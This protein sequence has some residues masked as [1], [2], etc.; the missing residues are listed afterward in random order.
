MGNIAHI[1]Q[2][3]HDKSRNF[4]M[5]IQDFCKHF[6]DV[7]EARGISPYWQ[8]TSVTSS[9]AR[10]SFP[11]IC[12]SSPTQAVFVLSQSDRRWT[13]QSRYKNSIGLR[14]YRSRTVAPPR[15]AVGVKQNVSSPFK[16]L[17]LLGKRELS[18]AHSVVIEVA[19]MEPNT[20]YIAAIDSEYPGANLL[21]R[22]YTACPPRLR[23][24]TQPE[25]Q[26]LLQAQATAPIAADHDSFSS[27]GSH[28]DHLDN[29]AHGM[30]S[31]PHPQ[32]AYVYEDAHY[33]PDHYG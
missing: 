6:N 4:W 28:A 26:Y 10:P 12:V 25:T 24:L 1:L 21:L 31:P 23:E 20:L 22:V 27:Q 30:M 5:S 18:K 15:N 9:S 3:Q 7:V 2:A 8:M 11:L 14:I 16:N 32:H 17:E 13:N 33:E 29:H 19:K